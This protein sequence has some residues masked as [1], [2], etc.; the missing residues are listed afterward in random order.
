MKTLFTTTLL[1]LCTFSAL[2][3]NNQCALQFKDDLIISH[4]T[5]QLQRGQQ[6]LWKIDPR[7]NLWLDN[8]A[9]RTDASTQ[10]ALTD[11]QAGLRSQS[12]ATVVLVADALAL[13]NDAVGSAIASL[14]V[15]QQ[16]LTSTA[17]QA[18][19]GLKSHI[20][21]LVVSNG[22]EI[23]IYGSQVNQPDGGLERELEQAIEQTIAQLTGAV[24][25]NVGA[26]MMQANGPAD[27]R[28]AQVGQKMAQF[29]SQMKQQ[30]QQKGKALEQRGQA[31]CSELQ[32]LD[33]LEQQIQQAIPAMQSYDLIDTSKPGKQLSFKLATP[34]G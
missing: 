7:G 3:A 24:M 17:N 27:Q 11:Y 9:V 18:I 30:M 26:A 4:N 22:D 13:A 15:N 10:Q 2:A 1:S 34:Q 25:M 28:M 16:P 29:G 5:V 14:G 32:Q 33:R 6:P 23:R 8:K 12:R 19:A 31:I 21:R 20:D